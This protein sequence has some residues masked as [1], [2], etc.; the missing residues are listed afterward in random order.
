VPEE[1]SI[2]KP[3]GNANLVRDYFCYTEIYREKKELSGSPTTLDSYF[4]RRPAPST[5][6][7]S[8]SLAL[9]STPSPIPSITASRS[10]AKSPVR[11]RLDLDDSTYDVED[12]PSSTDFLQ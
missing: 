4:Q 5:S 11:K 6:T 3:E 9:T 2:I 7:E 8:P 1:V 12:I 10:P